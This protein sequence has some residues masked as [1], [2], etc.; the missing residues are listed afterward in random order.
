MPTRSALKKVARIQ[1]AYGPHIVKAWEDF[2]HRHRTNDPRTRRTRR[3]CALV[4]LKTLKEHGYTVRP[5]D[6]NAEHAH[7]VMRASQERGL[8]LGTLRN[9]RNTLN[10]VGGVLDRALFA[11]SADAPAKTL[12]KNCLRAWMACVRNL[13]SPTG[14]SATR[15]ARQSHLRLFAQT[16]HYLGY[17][18]KPENV[19]PKH[20][21]AALAQWAKGGLSRRTINNRLSTLRLFARQIGKPNVVRRTNGEYEMIP[22]R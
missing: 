3:K 5:E 11:K 20:V 21:E 8:S 4:I 6:L 9:I 7:C 22:R 13:R 17:D 15:K 18:P 19:R 10:W 2:L 16:I 14:S 1:K 12:S